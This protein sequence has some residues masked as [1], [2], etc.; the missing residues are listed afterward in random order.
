[1]NSS[2]LRRRA[3][4]VAAQLPACFGGE[5]AEGFDA[6]FVRALGMQAFAALEG[7]ALAG[8]LHL[9]LVA[10]DQVHL[11]AVLLPVPLRQVIEGVRIEVAM[12]FAIDAHQQV[13]VEPRGDA[14]GVVVGGFQGGDVLKHV[15]A[16]DKARVRAEKD[17]DRAEELHRLGRRE[18]AQGRAGEE[19]HPRLRPGCQAQL[20]QLAA[21]GDL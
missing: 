21:V 14:L 1:M 10:A 3:E 7:E 20:R 11:H 5:L 2:D 12:Q 16:D 6:V 18:V 13:F 19:A 15:D 17:A 9:L 8:G 4:P